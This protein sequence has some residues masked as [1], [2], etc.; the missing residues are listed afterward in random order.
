VWQVAR[1]VGNRAEEESGEGTPEMMPSCEAL[2]EAQVVVAVVVVEELPGTTR[3]S[4]AQEPL[5]APAV[6]PA[7]V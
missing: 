1:E 5:T 2:E 4:V 3:A 6:Q 7:P